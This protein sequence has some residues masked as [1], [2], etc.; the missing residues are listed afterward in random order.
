MPMTTGLLVNPPRF[1]QPGTVERDFD[2]PLN[3]G[4]TTRSVLVGPLL[5]HRN[6]GLLVDYQL[7]GA[8]WEVQDF[9]VPDDPAA[10]ERL[11]G[12]PSRFSAADAANLLAIAR[13][14]TAMPL[15]EALVDELAFGRGPVAA[16]AEKVVPDDVWKELLERVKGLDRLRTMVFLRV[17]GFSASDAAELARHQPPGLVRR[18]KA[19]PYHLAGRPRARFG[20][21]DSI[22]QYAGYR[23]P[24]RRREAY[25]LCEVAEWIYGNG[26]THDL[27]A[28][29][30][31]RTARRFG[32]SPAQAQREVQL[33][34]LAGAARVDMKAFVHTCT[35]EPLHWAQIHARDRAA[36]LWASAPAGRRVSA[37]R[38]SAAAAKF[39]LDPTQRAALDTALD[40]GLSVVTG[41]PGT[42]KTHLIAALVEACSLAGLT[43]AVGAATGRAARNLAARG[44]LA[45]TVHKLLDLRPAGVGVDSKYRH[46]G[47][48]YP[49]HVLIV[50]EAGMLDAYVFEKV[51]WAV[52]DGTNVVLVGDAN[53]LPPVGPG[54]PFFDTLRELKDPNRSGFPPGKGWAELQVNHRQGPGSAIPALASKIIAT[55]KRTPGV[56]PLTVQDITNCPDARVVP[57]PAGAGRSQLGPVLANLVRQHGGAWQP[58]QACPPVLVLHPLRDEAD[59][60]NRLIQAMVNPGVGAAASWPFRVGDPVVQMVNDYEAPLAR[61]PGATVPVMNGEVGRVVAAYP[62]AFGGLRR[63]EVEFDPQ[64]VV[65]YEGYAIESSLSLAYVLTVHKAQGAEADV[66]VLVVPS[67]MRVPR[68]GGRLGRQA[69]TCP[70]LYTAVTRAR[71]RVVFVTDDPAAVVAAAQRGMGGRMTRYSKWI[72][73]V[74]V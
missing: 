11:F 16:A 74:F 64:R 23:N 52:R 73:G 31:R 8:V 67:G 33:A 30:E 61:Q 21:L 2:W 28:R 26:H 57:V 36:A 65:A 39:N 1:P 47:N 69:W 29:L 3:G 18:L 40:Y 48:P 49:C 66:A 6:L 63:V 71:T 54:R 24:G 34:M 51:L 27:L 60:L 53:Q 68:G 38:R 42:G 55:G 22:A 46:T 70:L 15:F 20:G 50:D 35:Y 58:G 37:R 72:R 4:V 59:Y 19:D 5:P 62:D 13:T 56:P 43:A 14:K 25:V 9:L 7:N 45:Q 12:D 17:H 32:L 41:G 10:W 44:V